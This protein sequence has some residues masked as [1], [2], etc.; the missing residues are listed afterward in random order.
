MLRRNLQGTFG[1]WKYNKQSQCIPSHIYLRTYAKGKSKPNK[2]HPTSKA[3][4]NLT[5]K[6]NVVYHFN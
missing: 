6:N 2:T 1:F 4:N 5:G 3:K